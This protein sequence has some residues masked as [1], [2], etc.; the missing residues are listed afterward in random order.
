LCLT[1]GIKSTNLHIIFD[2]SLDLVYAIKIKNGKQQK[3]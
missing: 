3:H 2:I 1:V